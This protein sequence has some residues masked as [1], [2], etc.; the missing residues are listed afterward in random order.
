MPSVSNLYNGELVLVV[1][2]GSFMGF[3]HFKHLWV[4]KCPDPSVNAA[5]KAVG[6]PFFVA[7][8]GNFL[9]GFL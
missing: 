7:N 6:V 8:L 4:T 5:K 2:S 9:R 3:I 1:S